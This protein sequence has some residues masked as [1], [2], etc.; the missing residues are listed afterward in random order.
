[1]VEKAKMSKETEANLEINK[2]V[3]V[4]EKIKHNIKV[5]EAAFNKNV[6]EINKLEAIDPKYAEL[7]ATLRGQQTVLEGLKQELLEQD[8][9][10]QGLMVKKAEGREEDYRVAVDKALT[11]ADKPKIKVEPPNFRPGFRPGFRK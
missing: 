5:A 7:D 11:E 4:L 10:I 3:I 6:V 2:A 1:M 9:A 8:A